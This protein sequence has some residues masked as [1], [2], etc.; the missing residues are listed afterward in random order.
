MNA[1]EK[2]QLLASLDE[3]RKALVNSVDG[4]APET[5]L[6][7]PSPG[8]W[9]IRDCVEHVAISE[10]YLFAQ[11]G[12]AQR[13]DA[14]VLNARREELI[15]VR[16]LDRSRRIECPEDGLPRGRFPTLA[17]ALEHFLASRD[18]T[19]RYVENID[20]ELE[21][22]RAQITAHP[23]LGAANCYEIL[24]TMAVHPRRHA[25]QIEEIKAAL[26]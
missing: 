21:D 7:S 4:I 20:V 5:A 17:A 19:A 2:V 12:K 15:P 8:A 11:I 26:E 9:S 10:D 25:L 24:L 18:R 13:R 22:L 3:S 1:I 6:R 16:G 14:P 23:V